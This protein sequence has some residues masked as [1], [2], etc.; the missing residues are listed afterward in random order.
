MKKK[1]CKKKAQGNMEI[2][3]IRRKFKKS[4]RR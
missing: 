3:R 4:K 2:G 1:G